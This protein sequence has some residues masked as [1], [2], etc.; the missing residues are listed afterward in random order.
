MQDGRA[1]PLDASPA[2]RTIDRQYAGIQYMRGGAALSALAVHSFEPAVSQ[3]A[4]LGTVLSLFFLISGFLVV[5][6]T[7]PRTRP[8]RFMLARFRRITPLYWLLTIFTATLLWG[9]VS[10]NSPIPFWHVFSYDPPL[11]WRLIAASLGFLPYWNAG[12]G[13]IQ[14]VIPPGWTINLEML[15]YAIFAL[16][17]CLPRRWMMPALTLAVGALTLTGIVYRPDHPVFWLWTHPLGLEFLAGAWI[18]HAWQTGRNMWSA[19]GW[20][21]LIVVVI[22][23]IQLAIQGFTPRMISP[24][25]GP[26]YGVLFVSVVNADS[27]GTG[28]RVWRLPL[29]IGDASYSIYLVQF[30]VMVMLNFAGVAHG[31]AFGMAQFVA[32]I[33]LGITIHLLLDDPMMRL[34]GRRPITP[35][36]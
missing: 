20:Y 19:L 30:S 31:F 24:L 12:S 29:L 6:I 11:P 26:I 25:F 13:T 1:S 5:S 4:T 36:G 22:F 10:W 17:L 14:P 28:L 9:G 16:T 27:R 33:V 23:L 18:A 8:H 32:S 21:A 3:I 7:S 2:L 35:S 15:Y 34:L